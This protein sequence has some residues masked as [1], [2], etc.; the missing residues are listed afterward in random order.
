MTD[1]KCTVVFPMSLFLLFTELF[2]E[3]SR[4]IQFCQIKKYN[5][6]VLWNGPASFD[7]KVGLC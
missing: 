6:S 7:D 1:N 4:I 5:N 2:I 3:M